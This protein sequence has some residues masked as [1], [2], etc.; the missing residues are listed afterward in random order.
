MNKVATVRCK[1]ERMV[2]NGQ[3]WPVSQH[4]TNTTGQPMSFLF[5]ASTNG[6][7]Q[8]RNTQREQHLLQRTALD[9]SRWLLLNNVSVRNV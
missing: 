2:L 5:D 8:K 4:N 3:L 1:K 9:A 6:M 7:K